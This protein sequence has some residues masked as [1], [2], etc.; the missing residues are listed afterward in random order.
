MKCLRGLCVLMAVFLF[1]NSVEAELMLRP[2]GLESGDQY[3]L[4]FTTS[5]TTDAVSPDIDFYDNFVQSLAD[6]AP[7]VGTWGL[8]WQA[9]ISVP[10][11]TATDHTET[12]PEEPIKDPI[13]FPVDGTPLY[14]VDGKR[15]AGSYFDFFFWGTTTRLDI[16]ELG[17]APATSFAWTGTLASGIGGVPAGSS[18]GITTQGRIA[19]RS[20]LAIRAQEFRST[21]QAHLYAISELIT[22]PEPRFR[23]AALISLVFFLQWARGAKS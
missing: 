9:F 3:R 20:G 2:P 22:V 5:A 16:T 6:E 12:T 14:R 7:I 23:F 1:V 13:A 4:M 21:E 11:Q 15:I 17:T 10:S 8:D 18:R 19:A